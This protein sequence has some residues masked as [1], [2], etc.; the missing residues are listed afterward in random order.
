MSMAEMATIIAP[1]GTRRRVVVVVAVVVV[2]VGV[3]AVVGVVV[4]LFVWV[5]GGGCGG[6]VG[7]GVGVVCWCW[8]D[9]RDGGGVAGWRWDL[10]CGGV[11]VGCGV[12]PYG[13]VTLCCGVLLSYPQ[14]LITEMM[15]PRLCCARIQ[16]QTL[17]FS[18]VKPQY[19]SVCPIIQNLP[20][21]VPLHHISPSRCPILLL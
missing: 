7:G 6:G 21:I 11:Y 13:G 5:G 1:R 20:I 10:L 4:V 18:C 9:G 14:G 3:V 16:V 8:W 17:V 12:S 2:I 15:I 19:H